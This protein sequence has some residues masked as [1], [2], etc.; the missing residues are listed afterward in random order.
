[1]LEGV[2]KITIERLVAKMGEHDGEHLIE[3]RGL[4]EQLLPRKI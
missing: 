3:L 2:G 4:R 1:M